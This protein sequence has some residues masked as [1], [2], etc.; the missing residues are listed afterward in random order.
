MFT[1]GRSNRNVRK[2]F[3]VNEIRFKHVYRDENNGLGKILTSRVEER[4]INFEPQ[5]LREDGLQ[6]SARSP[7]RAQ[8]NKGH[9]QIAASSASGRLVGWLYHHLAGGEQDWGSG[10]SISVCGGGS[11]AERRRQLG[12]Y[13][14]A[15][16][17]PNVRH[18]QPPAKV[19]ASGWLPFSVRVGCLVL[20]NATS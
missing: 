3:K 6:T 20:F 8:R 18:A 9:T 19:A 14:C 10:A 17:D 16:G 1:F 15:N 13:L 11:Q 4:F 2:S 7:Y 12:R 5:E